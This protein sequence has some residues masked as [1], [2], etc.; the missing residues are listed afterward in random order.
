MAESLPP[1]A[2]GNL[3]PHQDA[4]NILIVPDQN[5]DLKIQI[6][7]SGT[8]AKESD[9]SHLSPLSLP[10]GVHQTVGGVPGDRVALAVHP[11]DFSGDLEQ[12]VDRPAPPTPPKPATW[13]VKE[14]TE[15]WWPD[16]LENETGLGSDYKNE[17]QFSFNY[18]SNWM[19]A[20]GSKR[21]RMHA[22][23]GTYREDALWGFA[24]ENFTFSCVCDGAG[25]SKLSRIGSEYTARKLSEL[26]KKELGAHENEIVKCSKE[27]LPGNLRS[28][29]HH[30]V[31]SVQR[32][33][34]NLAAKGGMPPKDFRCTLLTTLH[35]RHPTGGIIICANVGDGFIA[36][37]RNG[38]T[39]ERIGTSD[40]GAFSGEVTC[41]MPD[42]EVAQYY[43]KS[44]EE[45]RPIPDDDV[46]AYMLCT[47]GIEDPFFPI[48]RTVD[49]IYSQLLDGYKEP[50]KDV[51]YP[52]GNEPASIIR[53]KEP[54]AELLKWLNFEKR[55]ENDDRTIALIYR[56]R[57]AENSVTEVAEGQ[58]A[59]LEEPSAAIQPEPM[60]K[61]SSDRDF[62][63]LRVLE[64]M[65]TG[66][67]LVASAFIV[68]LILGLKIGRNAEVSAF[69]R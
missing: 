23:H 31:D 8:P 4:S 9:A 17:L 7:G 57:L 64:A 33:L 50:I 54:G 21:G 30:C 41:F 44:L 25:A 68:G 69:Q 66:A 14:P 34:L 15:K 39:A 60:Q 49:D 51:T 27:S 65:I 43:K 32:E 2:E 28:I 59:V 35:Y 61:T 22:H 6:E 16:A 24:G 13:E 37:K 63:K 38:Q 20:A 11:K 47:D 10:E 58:K 40:S 53:S 67:L 3:L 55:G 29:L 42:P 18:G 48:H 1:E 62:A 45:N 52:A 46:E 36:V 5:E 26:V 56:S 19:L 12:S